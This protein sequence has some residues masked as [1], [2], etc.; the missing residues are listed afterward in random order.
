MD[1]IESEGKSVAEAVESAL[2]RAGLR[3]DQV[4]V[5]IL[6]EA[7]SG[8]LGLGAKPARIR[9]TEK[10]WGAEGAPSAPPPAARPPVER[11]RE[12][13]QGSTPP[14]RSQEPARREGR[15]ARPAN[16]D[17]RPA[18]AHDAQRQVP[19]PPARPAPTP[20]VARPVAMPSASALPQGTAKPE[21]RPIDT[22]AACS[23]AQSLLQETLRLMDLS[24]LALKVSWD[25]V[26]ERVRI[27][28]EGP[29]SER[30]CADEGRTLESLQLLLTL[31]LGRRLQAPVAAQVDV[32]GFW[33]KRER[34]ILS[35]AQKG[36]EEVKST[37]RACRLAPME[38]ALRRLVHRTLADHPDV[39]T[40][41]EGDG[42]WRKIVIRPRKG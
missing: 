17:H 28:V 9:L 20:E 34:E 12:P 31:M 40:A 13:R 7:S 25:G 37:G 2:K 14:R 19:P 4:E 18:R 35:Q 39:V 6:Q 11:R 26:Q 1:N 27:E 10:R 30:L 38:P 8:F 22:A 21:S 5:Q 33:Q 16:G 36:V 41:S 23:Q 24:D 29:Q 42:A 15:G 3:R 32:G